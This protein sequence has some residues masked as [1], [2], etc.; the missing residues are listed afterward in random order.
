MRLTLFLF[1]IGFI[2]L[3]KYINEGYVNY[4]NVLHDYPKE[5]E[6]YPCI[7][8]NIL[9]SPRLE[10]YRSYSKNK[11]MYSLN[12]RILESNDCIPNKIPTSF[13]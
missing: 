8:G 1:L 6:Y 5:N 13:Y 4:P 7:N 10:S 2:I 3:S 12:S 9:S 11:D